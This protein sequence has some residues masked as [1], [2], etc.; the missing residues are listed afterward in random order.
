M[1]TEERLQHI[2]LNQTLL[3]QRLSDLEMKDLE[4]QITETQGKLS[5][6]ERRKKLIYDKIKNRQ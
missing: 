2:E 4:A 1:T 3:D 5:S 6:L